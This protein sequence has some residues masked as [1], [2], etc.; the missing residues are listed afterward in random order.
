MDVWV[1][2]LLRNKTDKKGKVLHSTV[3]GKCMHAKSFWVAQES[4]YY[5]LPL[6]Q[7]SRIFSQNQ[8]DFSIISETEPSSPFQ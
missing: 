1:G 3:G 4:P 6:S 5:C 8:A 7:A 2:I